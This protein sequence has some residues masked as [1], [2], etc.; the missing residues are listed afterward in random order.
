M[1]FRGDDGSKMPLDWRCP[2]RFRIGELIG[3]SDIWWSS[4]DGDGFRSA[5]AAIA[6]CMSKQAMPLLDRLRSDNGILAFYDTGVVMGFEIDRDETRAVLLAAMGLIDEAC[7]RL[8]QYEA[9]WPLTAA[10][11]RAQNFV[12]E[13]RTRF[14][15]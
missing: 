12:A 8:K 3:P 10:S 15:C 14:G 7:E 5:M 13:F 6:S 1:A 11:E 9:K 2:I 4:K